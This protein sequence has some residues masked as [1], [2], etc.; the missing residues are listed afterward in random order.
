MKYVLASA[1]LAAGLALATVPALAGGD[2][3]A[4]PATASCGSGPFQG[5][6]IGASTGYVHQHADQTVIGAGLKGSSDDNGWLI[7]LY[8]G[9]NW[10]CGRF[11][12]G[13]ESDW[14]YVD[15]SSTT[16]ISGDTFKSSMDYLGTTRV[17]LG[18][19]VTPTTLLYGTVGIA[20][21][22]IKHAYASGAIPVTN[23][24]KD[25]DFGVAVGGGVEFLRG[26]RFGLKAEVL[27][28]NM[29]EHTMDFNYVPPGG[30]GGVCRGYY[31]W[32]DDYVVARLGL[33]YKFGV[34][35]APAVQ[36]LK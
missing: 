3:A 12:I 30:C 8:S 4:A 14:S 21:A 17:R 34:A 16:T 26:D 36:P 22:H 32:E 9:Y 2:I 15:A 27:Y 10:Q 6:Y 28:V 20:T 19:T 5:A 11:V 33:S 31:K 18:V 13:A 23:T 29:G 1:A 35:P 25:Y 7:G 24:D